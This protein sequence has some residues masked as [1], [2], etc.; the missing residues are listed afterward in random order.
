MGFPADGERAAAFPTGTARFYYRHSIVMQVE[1]L[2]PD[3][4]SYNFYACNRSHFG[5]AGE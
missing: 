2:L 4:L 3:K 1:R 5:R